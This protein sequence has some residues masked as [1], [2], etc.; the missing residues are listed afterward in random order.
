MRSRVALIVLLAA[1]LCG[2]SAVAFANP[3]EPL[4]LGGLFDAAD[5]DDALAAATWAEAT[6]AGPPAA[7]L[8]IPHVAPDGVCSPGDVV[9]ARSPLSA[10]RGRAP[11]I[12]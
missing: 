7:P 5:A 2:L 4:W 6:A 12:S 10:A 1:A 11:P 3:P 8:G 9:V